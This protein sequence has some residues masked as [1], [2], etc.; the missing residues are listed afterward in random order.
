MSLAAAALA[1]P[2]YID[3]ATDA[4]DA[5]ASLTGILET[6]G[7]CLDLSRD[8]VAM[9]GNLPEEEEVDL[10]LLSD[11]IEARSELFKAA[12]CNFAALTDDA[13][14]DAAEETARLQLTQQAICLLEE[15]TE[16]ENRLSSFLGERLEKMRGTINNM[17]KA[18]P[19]F[20]RYGHLGGN[21]MVPSR[22][23][24]HE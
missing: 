9:S 11:F 18:Q 24:I 10:D 15:M 8:Y 7:Q 4:P 20:R 12:E 1:E 17:Q 23:N 19:V 3:I 21:K 16:V 6:Y 13:S 2:E 22:I 14:E 5:L